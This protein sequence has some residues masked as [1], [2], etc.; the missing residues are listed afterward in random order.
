MQQH[1]RVLGWIY[2]IFHA[3]GLIGAIITFIILAGSGMLVDDP[4]AA[5]ILVLI[6]T[7]LGA[8]MAILSIPG[9]IGGIFLMRY[10]NWARILVLILGFLNLFNFPLGTALGI[11][12][13]YVL[14]HDDTV[15]LFRGQGASAQA[16]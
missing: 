15:P 12:T 14:I 1:V 8:F 11:Y 13:I 10:E 7:A 2:I 5:P 16:Q 4:E 3:F 6:G 9:I